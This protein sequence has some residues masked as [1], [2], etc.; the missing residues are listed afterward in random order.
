MIKTRTWG[1]THDELYDLIT[2][3][4]EAV[5]SYYQCPTICQ[6]GCNKLSYEVMDHNNCALKLPICPLSAQILGDLTTY[7]S[8]AGRQLRAKQFMRSYNRHKNV[9]CLTN[10]ILVMENPKKFLSQFLQFLERTKF[11]Y[12]DTIDTQTYEVM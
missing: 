1:L 11:D 4:F 9:T 8:E 12:V 2:E 10:A 3:K 5:L 6:N 7:N